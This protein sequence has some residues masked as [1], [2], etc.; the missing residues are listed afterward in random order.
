MWVT[1]SYRPEQLA[2]LAAMRL[3][4]SFVRLVEGPDLLI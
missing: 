1:L 3:M 4:Q 2:D